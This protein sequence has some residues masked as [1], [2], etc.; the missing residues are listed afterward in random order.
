MCEHENF[1]VEA[2]VARL[3]DVEDG[4][5]NGF[6][7]DIKILCMDCGEPFVFIGLPVGLDPRRPMSSLS[8]TELRAP[9]RPVSSPSDFGQV[10]KAA[11]E[12]KVWTKDDLEHE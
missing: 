2:N 3:S 7:A 4:P 9:I 1:A 6:S 12:M 5:I 11:F 8:G 10:G